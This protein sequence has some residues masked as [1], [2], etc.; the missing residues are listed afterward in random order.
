MLQLAEN[1]SCLRREAPDR[2][3]VDVANPVIWHD[4]EIRGMR[5][6]V[7]EKLFL[8][9]MLHHQDEL[10]CQRLWLDA[11]TTDLRQELLIVAVDGRHELPHPHAGDELAHHHFFAAVLEI[12]AWCRDALLLFGRAP[13]KYVR[14]TRFG[15]EVQLIEQNRLEVLPEAPGDPRWN[16]RERFPQDQDPVQRAQ[17]GGNQ[18]ADA[19]P[20]HLD[21]HFLAGLQL[22]LVHA[23]QRRG[24]D[25]L[26]VENR[27][28]VTERP[29]R[30][31][32]R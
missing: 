4:D 2:P 15:A 31:C 13:A 8:H 25:R 18:R 1:L 22:G 9:L 11:D 19:G 3:E 24:A 27:E 5:I 21:C 6:G 17:V 20:P 26:G 23:R 12:D 30:D 14:V 10:A 7:E 32:A 28:H 29:R 16:D